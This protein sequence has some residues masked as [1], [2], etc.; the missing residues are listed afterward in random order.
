M[1]G[2]IFPIP[3]RA[4]SRGFETH[5]G[6]I[7]GVAASKGFDEPAPPD[8]ITAHAKAAFRRMDEILHAAGLDRSHVGF[9]NVFLHDVIRDVDGFNA[10]WHEVFAHLSPA[11]FCVGARLQSLML[12]EMAFYAERPAEG[13]TGA[14]P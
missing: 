6:L 2:P 13:V 12:V 11:R 9:V 4:Q 1:T 8:D 7:F 14:D 3:G 5:G 10:V